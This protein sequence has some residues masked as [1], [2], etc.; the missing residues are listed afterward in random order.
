MCLQAL[1]PNFFHIMY[2][3]EE[4]LSLLDTEYFDNF[5]RLTPYQ[6]RTWTHFVDR[7]LPSSKNPYFQNEARC[8]T[9]LVKVSFICMRIKND[10]HI[11]GWAPTL[12]LKQRLG[13]TRKWPII[14]QDQGRLLIIEVSD[15]LLFGLHQQAKGQD[16]DYIVIVWFQKKLSAGDK[17]SSSPP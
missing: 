1:I 11:K 13:G 2:P 16:G 12:L 15:D 9:F 6:C 10:F 4:K 3:K 17:C 5:V 7:P 8:T 14:T